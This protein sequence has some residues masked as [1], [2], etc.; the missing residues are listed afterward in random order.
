MIAGRPSP[1]TRRYGAF[2]LA[3]AALALMAG[4]TE[5]LDFDMR[6][7]LG[8]FNTS[9]AARNAS[10]SRPRPDNRGII[11]YPNYQVAV[12]R[13]GD[14]VAQL[15]ARVGTS[16][17]DLA[18]YNGLQ[19]GDTLREGEVIALPTR[20]AEPSPATGALGTGPILPAVD[21]ASVAGRALDEASAV[22]TTTLDP[23]P[24]AAA[25][26][27]APATPAA[28]QSGDEPIRHKVQ[29]GETA[30]TVSRLYKVSVRSLAEWNGLDEN[31]TIR[32]G[33]YLL[34]PPVGAQAAPAATTRTEAPGVGSP[35]PVPPSSAEP[36][37][38]EKTLPQAE[39]RAQASQVAAAPDLSGGTSV[40]TPRAGAEMV[41]PVKGSIIRTYTKGKTDGI[42]IAAQPGS[43][44]VAA[45]AGSVAAITS[46][47]DNVH[48]IVLRHADGLL[49]IYSNVTGIAV[50][51]GQQVSQGAKIA[52]IRPG[53]SPYV[54]FEVRRGMNSTDPMPFLD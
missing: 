48:V 21:V 53:A 50:K 38:A 36:L 15:A 30:F 23:A 49:T 34:I 3:T 9:E 43:S 33:Q 32:E 29:R 41:Y 6:G 28:G 20:V 11:S 37:P 5:P 1:K 27:Q 4:C 14:S 10:M 2:T 13:Q 22:Q 40:T 26:A 18:R 45:K 39:A 52:E 35:T 47:S 7:H 25:P 12:A 54:H 46:D 31:F 24:V 44:V 17:E 16:A 19:T 8:A 51:E 42:D